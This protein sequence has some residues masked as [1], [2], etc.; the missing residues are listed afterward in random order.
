[1]DQKL[2]KQLDSEE[3]DY[4]AVKEVHDMGA[5]E[6][7]TDHD[8]Y[9]KSV[10]GTQAECTCGWGLFVHPNELRDGHVYAGDK[11]VV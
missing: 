5:K 10:S 8:H 4:E 11:L 2:K 1:M 9:F 6:S 7:V 3:K